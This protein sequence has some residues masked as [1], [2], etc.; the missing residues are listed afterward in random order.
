MKFH[1]SQSAN[2]LLLL[3]MGGT[4]EHTRTLCEWPSRKYV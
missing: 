2:V 3:E 1:V 4:R